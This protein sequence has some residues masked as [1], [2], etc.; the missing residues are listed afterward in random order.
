MSPTVDFHLANT[1][2]RANTRNQ[3][4]HF[5]MYTDGF[6]DQISGQADGHTQFQ[7][8]IIIALNC[9]LTYLLI[10]IVIQTYREVKTHPSLLPVVAA[11][12]MK[13]IPTIFSTTE[14]TPISHY[15]D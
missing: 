11:L 10:H 1:I 12:M 2:T 8:S 14:R 6:K 9:P 4:N 13:L 7:N 5:K 3:C 15:R